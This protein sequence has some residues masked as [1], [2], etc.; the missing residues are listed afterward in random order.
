MA[1]TIPDML[2]FTCACG[3]WFELPSLAISGRDIIFC[4]LCGTQLEWIEALDAQIRREIIARAREDVEGVIDYLQANGQISENELTPEIMQLIL[5]E[6]I[7]NRRA[8]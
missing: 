3:C 1:F 6:V 4:P 8:G 5:K 7:R 2:R